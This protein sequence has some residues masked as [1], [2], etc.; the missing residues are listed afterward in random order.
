MLAE[1]LGTLGTICKVCKH[2][3]KRVRLIEQDCRDTREVALMDFPELRSAPRSRRLFGLK[4]EIRTAA[5]TFG[6]V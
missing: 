2:R 3:L 5:L 6:S 1:V 4:P